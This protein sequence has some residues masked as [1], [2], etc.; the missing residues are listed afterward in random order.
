MAR[1]TTVDA[2]DIINDVARVATLTDTGVVRVK[3]YIEYGAF[4]LGT[5]KKFFGS[6][7]NDTFADI[8]T[9]ETSDKQFDKSTVRMLVRKFGKQMGAKG[10]TMTRANFKA[11]TGINPNV[12][13]QH[14]GSFNKGV[15][16]AGFVM[17]DVVPIVPRK[18][19]KDKKNREHATV[20][21]NKALVLVSA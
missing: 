2:Q 13:A 21:N 14:F 12:V 7:T 11:Y 4:S 5:V 17:N 8:L 10:I 3:N 9:M 1:T 20:P 6:S 15:E 18:V 16:D 19:R